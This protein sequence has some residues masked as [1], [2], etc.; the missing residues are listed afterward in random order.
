MAVLLL[1]TPQLAVNMMKA[2]LSFAFLCLCRNVRRCTALPTNSD[3]IWMTVVGPGNVLSPLK[4]QIQGAQRL[5]AKGF[6]LVSLKCEEA[7]MAGIVLSGVS[8]FL[9]GA[10]VQLGGGYVLCRFC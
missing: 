1:Y 3:S 8:P 7:A 2:F 5:F 6:P 4:R 9:G 10:R